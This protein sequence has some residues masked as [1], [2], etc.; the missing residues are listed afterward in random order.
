MDASKASAALL[1]LNSLKIF[2]ILCSSDDQ[3]V[4]TDFRALNLLKR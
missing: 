3:L 4:N 1:V 2:D